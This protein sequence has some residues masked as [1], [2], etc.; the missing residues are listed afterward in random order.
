[1]VRFLPFSRVVLDELIHESLALI[2]VKDHNFDASLLQIL[3]TTHEGLI[4]SGQD[5]S[6]GAAV[7]VWIKAK[8]LE[9]YGPARMSEF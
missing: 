6:I 9:Q 3:L 4:L 2:I 8:I 5:V 1:L 7:A